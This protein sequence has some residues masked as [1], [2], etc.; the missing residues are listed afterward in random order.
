M[1]VY[2]LICKF[3]LCQL[4]SITSSLIINSLCFY[5]GHFRDHVGSYD[6]MFY[7][8]GGISVLSGGLWLLVP[9][10]GRIR[11]KEGSQQVEIQS[12]VTE[13]SKNG[14]TVSSSNELKPS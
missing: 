10:M 7:L 8:T 14:R 13:H 9:T 1:F 11:R 6:G 12:I 5:A 3:D 4:P 2:V